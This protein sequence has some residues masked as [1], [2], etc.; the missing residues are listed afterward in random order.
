MLSPHELKNKEFTKSLRGYSTV[1]VDEHI[2]F[3]I[4]KYTDLYRDNDELEKQLRLAKAQIDGLK[5]EEESIRTTLINAQ[6]AST[7]I[8]NEA[9]ERADVIMRSAKTNCDRIIAELKANVKKEN[10]RLEA[11]RSEVAMFKAALFEIYRTHIELVE[12]IAPDADIS[13]FEQI[14]ADKSAREVVSRIKKDLSGRSEAVSSASDDD[15]IVSVMQL[16]D[17]S[18]DA[19]S[20]GYGAETFESGSEY[21]YSAAADSEDE[22]ETERTVL[23]DGNGKGG[24]IDSIRKINNKVPLDSSDD[25]EF[26]KLLKA[27]GSEDDD[28]D[29][30]LSSTDEFD[31]V[32]DSKRK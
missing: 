1:E 16:A 32:Y 18:E 25:E 9:N 26:L 15:E 2:N 28:D 5:G 13:E 20:D 8:I 30:D 6:K 29:S 27:A 10:E 17:A 7:R 12:K 11:V 3:I 23:I 24:L 19:D 22:L 14:D 31:I 21:V 4:E